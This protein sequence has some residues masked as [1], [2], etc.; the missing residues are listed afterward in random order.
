LE[1]V[2][3][4]RGREFMQVAPSCSMLHVPL[5]LELETDLDGDLRSWLSFSIQKMDELSTL[6]RAL[7]G[8]RG[9]VGAALTESAAA[10]ASR[11]ASPKVH[12]SAVAD[13]VA[14]IEPRMARRDGD[15]AAR[16]GVQ[17]SRLNLPLFP[18]TTIGSFP[19]TSRV[20]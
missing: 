17:R 13:R 7:D 11:R 20:R 10:A 8:G 12:D 9:A 2:V 14:S 19:Q 15:F 4:A 6:G 5:D 18:T 16:A 1:P 3:A